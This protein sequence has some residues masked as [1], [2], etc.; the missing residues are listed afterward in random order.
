MA[1]RYQRQIGEQGASAQ[2]QNFAAPE[3]FGAMAAGA[4]AGLGE[5]LQDTVSILTMYKEK[6]DKIDIIA[7]TN[8]YNRRMNAYQHD[9]DNGQQVLRKLNDARGLLMDTENHADEV[10]KDILSRLSPEAAAMFEISEA[11]LRQPFSKSAASYETN[12]RDTYAKASADS[13]LIGFIESIQADPHNNDMLEVAID[14]AA[15]IIAENMPGA[16]AEM[17]NQAIGSYASKADAARISTIANTDPRR[18]EQMIAESNYL[19]PAEKMKLEEAVKSKVMLIK[20][21]ETVDWL[22]AENGISIEAETATR[23][24]IRENY[25]GEEEEQL[26]SK[27]GQ[28]LNEARITENT[29][30]VSQSRQEQEIMNQLYMDYYSKGLYVPQEYA[31]ELLMTGKISYQKHE[32]IKRWNDSLGNFSRIY[33]ETMRDP[34]NQG[35]SQAEIFQQ[36]QA[37]AGISKDQAINAYNILRTGI[38]SGDVTN[39]EITHARVN[40]LI[41]QSDAENLEELRRKYIPSMQAKVRMGMSEFN[42]I[43]KDFKLTPEE[44]RQARNQLTENMNAEVNFSHG[45]EEV[46][47]MINDVIRKTLS[48]VFENG[49]L[50]GVYA[51]RANAAIKI[52]TYVE[53]PENNVANIGLTPDAALDTKPSGNMVMGMVPGGN[54]ISSGYDADR[55]GGKR[56]H[57]AI[58]VAAPAGT[59]IFAPD[60][61]AQ[62]VVQS[63]GYTDSTGNMVELTGTDANGKK[64]SVKFMHLLNLSG[65][66]RG[67]RIV[68]GQ[69]ISYVGNTGKTSTGPHL[70]IEMTIDG[71]RVNPETYLSGVAKAKGTKIADSID[72][73]K[74][75]PPNARTTDN[76]P[77]SSVFT[78]GAEKPPITTWTPGAGINPFSPYTSV[79][80]PIA[81]QAAEAAKHNAEQRKQE[82]RAKLEDAKRKK[83]STF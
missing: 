57:Q 21:Q 77:I 35:S 61:G 44:E 76:T 16:G 27:Y 15:A 60:F 12:E 59:K 69:V 11:Q 45:D 25:E 17:V 74:P 28:R 34:R 66:K 7:A 33:N 72:E 2:G 39:S 51:K 9:P 50:R 3:A 52:D 81:R 82:E 26:I 13:A 73:T 58:D 47:K 40:G 62:M 8:D 1:E 79:L 70:H 41:S 24:W 10:K 36:A 31:D 23:S 20:T 48:Q 75:L 55:D 14:S 54:R 30:E 4:I 43:L 67:E 22:I 32:Q 71:K 38:M 80:T 5:Q 68:N 56:K 19:K 53:Y 83:S 46:G 6:Q 49:K 63:F 42:K 29:N 37:K 65:L 64:I 18:A 78:P